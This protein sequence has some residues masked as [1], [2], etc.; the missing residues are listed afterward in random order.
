MYDVHSAEVFHK[1]IC[2]TCGRLIIIT[3]LIKQVWSWKFVEEMAALWFG[4]FVRSI[5]NYS[6]IDLNQSS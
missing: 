5:V 6:Q 1:E 2:R 4:Y 3:A